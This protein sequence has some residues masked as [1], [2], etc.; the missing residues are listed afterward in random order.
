MEITPAMAVV[1]E[2]QQEQLQQPERSESQPWATLGTPTVYSLQ[3]VTPQQEDGY[4]R[5]KGR[6][7]W[8]WGMGGVGEWAV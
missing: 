7:V 2:S 5:R 6:K 8:G 1:S 4:Q 3:A